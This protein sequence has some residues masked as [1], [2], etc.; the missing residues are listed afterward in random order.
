MSCRIF[1]LSL[2][3]CP[4]VASALPEQ[5]QENAAPNFA[6]YAG[7]YRLDSGGWVTITRMGITRQLAKPLFVDWQTGRFG[8]IAEEG[9]DRFVAP[10]LPGAEPAWQTEIQ[11]S[12]DGVGR[13]DALTIAE[14]GEPARGARREDPFTDLEVSFADGPVVLSGTLRMPKGEGPFPG[15]VLVHG[16]GPGE[17][18]QYSVMVSFFSRLGLATLAYDKRGCG[19]SSGDW[20]KVDLEDL[21]ADALAGMKWLSTQPDIDSKKVGLWGISQGGWITPLAA[22]MEPGVPAFVINSSGPGTS[23]R[24]Q[25][26]FMMTNT[27][28]FQGMPPEDIELAIMALNTLYDF[29]RGR[30]TA[31]ALDAIMDKVR[32]NPKL[33]ALAIPPAR[34]IS[35]EKLYA[36]QAIGDP[37]WFFHLDPD[38]DALA[39]YRRLRSPLLVTYGRLDY[40]VPVEESVRLI[41]Q[42]LEEA[43]G[44]DYQVQ[45]LETA[46]HG[47]AA[48]RP[49]RPTSPA[50]PS[51]MAP[52]FFGTL[53]KWL[54][55][56]GFTRP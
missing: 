23:L 20:K 13:V 45:V 51:R 25:D 18:E 2:L 27:L 1:F 16:S 12:R 6:A 29:G 26:T 54:R 48:M 11:F 44:T 43:G 47:F 41:N 46:G 55:A 39:P 28:R 37:A 17:R 49:D 40:T 38:R 10:A 34:E 52:E 50:Q 5:K 53:E 19:K 24:H 8:N 22:A 35:A 30:A 56:H 15:I 7:E 3:L 36:R 9:T 42:T 21:A 32:A 33:K 4:Y 31:E 14:R